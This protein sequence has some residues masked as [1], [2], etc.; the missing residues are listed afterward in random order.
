MDAESITIIVIATATAVA[1]K[2]YLFK[3]IRQ[4]V[5]NDLINSLSNGDSARKQALLSLYQDL[6]ARGVKRSEL[7]QELQRFAEQSTPD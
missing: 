2:W 3:R 4:W 6:K 7:H 5:D 1:F